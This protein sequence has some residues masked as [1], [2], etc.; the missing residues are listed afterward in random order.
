MEKNLILAIVLSVV[1]LVVYNIFFMPKPPL[2]ESTSTS[3]VPSQ[4]EKIEEKVEG[5]PFVARGESI[6]LENANI[7]LQVNTE[8]GVIDSW[9]IKN[10][11]IFLE[12]GLK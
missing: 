11:L 8:G 6:T 1:V 3:Q 12:Q 9:Y 10:Y 5:E 7:T 2:E 4:E